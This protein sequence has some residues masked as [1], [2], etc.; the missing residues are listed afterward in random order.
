MERDA[1]DRLYVTGDA[2]DE[3]LKELIDLQDPAPLREAA[4]ARRKEW[5]GTDV[6]V[7]GLIEFSNHCRNNCFYC[8][9]RSGNR[10]LQRYRLTEDDI[11]SCAEGGYRIGMRTFVLQSGEDPCFD[12]GSI[13]SVV[14]SLKA[15]HPDC[16]VTLSIGEKPKSAYE[17]YFEAGADR[18]LLR[19][20]TASEE[21]YS[22]LHPSSMSLAN[23]KRCLRDLKETGFQTGAGFI[24]GTPWQTIDNLVEDLR[25]LQ[26]LDPEMIGI[27]PFLPASGTPFESMPPGSLER[28]LNLLS[29]LRL[30][31]PRALIPAT[32]SLGTIHPNGL[33]YGLKA[34]ANVIMPNLTPQKESRL[35]SLYDNKPMSVGTLSMTYGSLAERVQSV[36]YGIVTDRGDVAVSRRH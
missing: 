4:D 9:I 3:A 17:A 25:F 7:R 11:L 5:Y 24:V 26:S 22:M 13:C 18:Y 20:E 30:M 29:I 16:A 27:G 35:Y 14:R 28:T 8:G 21:H 19:H 10:P 32:T 1:V 36:G 31:F 23:R 34:G 15:A 12:D 2:S 6:F 33:E